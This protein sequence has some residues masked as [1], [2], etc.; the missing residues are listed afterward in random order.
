MELPPELSIIQRGGGNGLSYR[1]I[2][3]YLLQILQIP[4]RIVNEKP[5]INYNGLLSR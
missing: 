1:R 5:E 4:L 3:P 2:W